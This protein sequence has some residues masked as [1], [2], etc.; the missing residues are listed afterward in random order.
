MTISYKP[1]WKLLIDRD[2]KKKDLCKM[3]GISPATITKMGK[4]GQISTSV[5]E[6]ICSALQCSL[7]DVMETVSDP[8]VAVE[9][10]M[11]NDPVVAN[12]VLNSAPAQAKRNDP[13]EGID[14]DSLVDIRNVKI[15]T[16]LPVLERIKSYIEQVKNPYYFRVGDVAVHVS[17]SESGPSLQDI[18]EGYFRTFGTSEF[19][20]CPEPKT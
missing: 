1:L 4:G 18:L 5:L 9:V 11:E 3:A 20:Q 10:A 17:Y 7:T 16:S 12:K 13:F 14:I 8:P 6:K 19:C 2:I 15:D